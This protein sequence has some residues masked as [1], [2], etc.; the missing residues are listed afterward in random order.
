MK[1]RGLAMQ[2]WQSGPRFHSALAILA[3]SFFMLSALIAPPVQAQIELPSIE[4]PA[5]PVDPQPIIEA[6]TISPTDAEIEERIEGIFAEIDAL[7][8]VLV[9]VDAGVVALTGPASS[10][11]A[12]AC[13][14]SPTTSS[15]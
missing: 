10:E 4:T 1:Y 12:I 2:F 13:R 9:K 8:G 5:E 15:R 6:Q 3:G 7:K 11:V 14:T